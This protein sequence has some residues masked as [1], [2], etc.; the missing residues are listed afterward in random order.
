MDTI[1]I[2]LPSDVSALVEQ[3]FYER[4]MSFHLVG[5]LMGRS[6]VRKDLLE[7]YIEVAERRDMELELYKKKIVDLYSPD[8]A[9]SWSFSFDFENNELIFTEGNN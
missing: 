1:T 3:K 6:D 7:E 2:K 9:K 4:N 5:Y 8:P